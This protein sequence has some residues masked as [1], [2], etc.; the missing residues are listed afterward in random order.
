MTD[1]NKE[2]LT[3]ISS[4]AGVVSAGAALAGAVVASLP[5]MGAAAVLG[6]AALVIGG[7]G[8]GSKPTVSDS[9]GNAKEG[10]AG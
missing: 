5:V 7:T 4:T 3:I 2:A 1:Q 9:K 6:V 10:P 8:V